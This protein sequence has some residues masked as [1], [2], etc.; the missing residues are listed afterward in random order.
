MKADWL[1]AL[2]A[3][4]VGFALVSWLLALVRQQKAPPVAI[5]SA[6][7]AA[8]PSRGRLSLA[9]LGEE[10]HRLL[11]VGREATP[12]EIE[13]A[14]QARLAECERVRCDADA[15]GAEKEAALRRRADLQDAYE[16]IRPQ[17]R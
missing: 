12:E 13:A 10:W 15:G 3:A 9:A 17:R 7:S 1:V 2:I 8:P 6:T 16:F 14:Y 4:V 11:G 5:A